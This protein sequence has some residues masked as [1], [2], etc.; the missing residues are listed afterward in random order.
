MP[1][2][3]VHDLD[4]APREGRDALEHQAERVGKVLNIF[5]EMAHSPTLIGLYDTVETY[6]GENSSLEPRVREAIHLT[7]A[8]VN[9]CDYCQAAYTGSAKKQGF[10][11]EQTVQIRRGRVEGDEKLTALLQVAREIAADRGYVEDGTWKEALEAGWSRR[12]VLDAYADVVR[13]ILTN[14]F[15]HLVGTEVDL[16]EPP[17]LD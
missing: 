7:V 1:R 12:E 2:V 13:T 9:A 15:N 16:P 17:P 8:N 10:S 6:L 14:Y 4:D 5:G 3:P 11:D